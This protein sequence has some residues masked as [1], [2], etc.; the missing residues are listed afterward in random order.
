M[1]RA[2]LY[3]YARVTVEIAHIKKVTGITYIFFIPASLAAMLAYQSLMA[4]LAFVSP[5]LATVLGALEVVLSFMVQTWEMGDPANVYAIIGSI[6]VLVFSTII[7][8]EDAFWHKNKED[9]SDMKMEKSK[10]SG[11]E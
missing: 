10:V 9:M 3:I 7:V 1:F 6:L 2:Q 5:T 8:L 4:A 11:E